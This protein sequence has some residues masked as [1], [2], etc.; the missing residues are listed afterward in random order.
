M[1]GSHDLVDDFPTFAQPCDGVADGQLVGEQSDQQRE[2]AQQNRCQRQRPEQFGQPEYE[3][4][5]QQDVGRKGHDEEEYE[6]AGEGAFGGVGIHGCELL[7]GGGFFD[8][9][10]DLVV[11]V[12]DFPG[13]AVYE[14][15]DLS[16]H[17]GSRLR[18][19]QQGNDRA[20][21]HTAQ[22]REKTR[23]FHSGKMYLKFT[24]YDCKVQTKSVTCS[25]IPARSGRRRYDGE[26]DDALRAV[27]REL[28]GRGFRVFWSGMAL[29]F[30]L[31]AAE[32]VLALRGELPGLRLCCAVPFP[33]Q[34]DR[35]PEAD[36]LRYMRILD[37]ADE[38]ATLAPRYEPRCYLR[39]DEFMVER[40]AAVV[41][42]FDGGKG[43]TR[44][45][46]DYARRCK[47]ERINLWCDGQQELF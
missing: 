40:S 11:F 15:F 43:G 12:A 35:F 46:W 26:C 18:G 13:F 36:R 25:I 33:G 45:T 17:F 6:C 29:G 14:I 42:W 23:T 24:R 8:L 34:A 19:S 47:A 30:D 10:L 9:T 20:E 4:R 32:A 5:H 16:P 38:V 3:R 39:R 31:A 41:A 37:R 21:H 44:Y 28:Y 7:F 27:V 2:S 22:H 1:D